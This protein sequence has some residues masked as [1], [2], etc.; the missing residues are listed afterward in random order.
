MEDWQLTLLGVGV[1]GL[2][3][4]AT[5]LVTTVVQSRQ[6]R[7]RETRGD[8]RSVRRAARRHVNA[9]LDGVGGLERDFVATSSVSFGRVV[10]VLDA[11][12]RATSYVDDPPLLRLLMDLAELV[13]QCL[14]P[15]ANSA[16]GTQQVQASVLELIGERPRFITDI[17][18]RMNALGW[19]EGEL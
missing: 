5:G 2:V 16:E 9:F 6:E 19:P 18:R 17:V 11:Y 10:D 15:N 12:H 1:G 14:V 8:A 4:V 3:S 13:R 7:E